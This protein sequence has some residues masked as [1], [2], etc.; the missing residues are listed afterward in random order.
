MNIHFIKKKREAG[1]C[2]LSRVH[3]IRFRYNAGVLGHRKASFT[4]AN[5]NK[6]KANMIYKIVLVWFSKRLT[7]LIRP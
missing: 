2:I 4:K 6:N 5:K 7:I 1:L 3:D